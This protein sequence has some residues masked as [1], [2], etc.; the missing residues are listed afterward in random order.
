MNKLSKAKE[1]GF[2]LYNPNSKL[3]DLSGASVI[4]NP[5]NH[6]GWQN[7]PNSTNQQSFNSQYGQSPYGTSIK[8]NSD[9]E[10]PIIQTQAYLDS[11]KKEEQEIITQSHIKAK[12]E[13]ISDTLANE[14]KE[15]IAKSHAKT[16][17]TSESDPLAAEKEAIIA[18]SHAKAKQEQDEYINH[19]KKH[20]SST[21]DSALATEKLPLAVAYVRTQTFNG[22]NTPADALRQG[23]AFSELYRPYSP[24][25]GGPARHE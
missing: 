9:N 8:R 15:I 25:K 21:K 6:S 13:H 18:K 19:K 5:Y 20:N 14:K 22:I 12:Q 24:K 1:L 4:Y 7:H 10:T 23:T 11:I 17:Q 2:N 16:K 3:I